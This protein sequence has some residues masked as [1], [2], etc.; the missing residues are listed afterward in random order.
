[1]KE[2]WGNILEV[3][4]EIFSKKN[5]LHRIFMASRNVASVLAHNRNMI[6]P[7]K[8]KFGGNCIAKNDYPLDKKWLNTM[9]S[10]W[11]DF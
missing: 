5:P 8:S 11:A 6:Y 2:A 7:K 9:I 1:M 10:Y 4:K 3:C